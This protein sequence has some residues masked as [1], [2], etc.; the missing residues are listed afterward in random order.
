MNKKEILNTAESPERLKARKEAE[1]LVRKMGGNFALMTKE[2][3][4]GW[5]EEC[6]DE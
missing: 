3:Q 5:I 4:D 1:K 6:L 2:E